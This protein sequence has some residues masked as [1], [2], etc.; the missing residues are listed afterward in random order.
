MPKLTLS[1][2]GRVIDVFHL[3]ADSTKIGRDPDCAI[4][5]DSLAIAPLQATITES[6]DVYRLEAQDE[7]FPVLVNHEKTEEINLHHGDVIQIGKHTL[8]FAEDVMELG[9]DLTLSPSAADEQPKA[10]TE[11]DVEE[12]EDSSS[13]VLQ[14]V[15]GD[16]FGRIISLHRHMTR[17]GHTGGDCAMIARREEGYYISFLEGINP[18][19]VNKQPLADQGQLLND[20][21]LI[22]VGGTQM[23]FHA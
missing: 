5:I 10:E 17:I 22:E 21:D 4:S 19:T 8:T 14:I 16:N 23:Q 1:F 2:K 20:G 9:A 11:D 3:E 6:G 15:N 12:E 13:S 18:P 7:E